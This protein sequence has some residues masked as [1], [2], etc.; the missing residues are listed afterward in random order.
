MLE[1]LLIDDEK[2]SITSLKWE[3]EQFC[4]GISVKASFTNPEEARDYLKKHQVDCIFLDIEMPEMDGFQF[5]D[6]FQDR[7]FSV[8]FVTAYDQYAIKAIKE[9]ALDYLLKPIDSDDLVTT[10]EKLK[11]EKNEQLTKDTIEDSLRALSDKRIAIP[12]DGKL[13]FLQTK[14]VL[15]CESDGN[16]CTIYLENNH[17]I[18]VT[19][20]LKEV[21]EILPEQYFFR[22][23][24]SYVVNLK[25]VREYFKTDGYVVLENQKKIPVSRSKRA[26]FLE[27]I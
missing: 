8:V 17:S 13:V 20:K 19:K 4:D 26:T 10:V 2:K 3:L 15:Y 24:N 9:R 22:V 27:K 16:Y 18:F 25:K 23:H 7:N 21:Q 12:V 1:V 11:K 6:S 5:L 14:E